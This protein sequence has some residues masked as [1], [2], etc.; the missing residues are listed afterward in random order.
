MSI[1]R[2]SEPATGAALRQHPPDQQAGAYSL[3]CSYIWSRRP[4]A[5][6]PTVTRQK[7]RGLT[8]NPVE[9]ADAEM[10]PLRCLLLG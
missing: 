4:L 6:A 3:L 8:L 7:M 1:P 9:M 5:I 2:E 10:K